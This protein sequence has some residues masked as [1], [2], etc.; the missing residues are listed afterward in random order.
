MVIS[1][2]VR[3]WELY[4]LRLL[5][6]GH[7]AIA[8]LCSLAGLTFV[9]EAIQL[10]E[11]RRFLERLLADEALP[12]LTEIPGHPREEYV[13][14]V[15]ERFAQGGV[16]DQLARLCIGGTA[17]FPVFLVPTVVD[18][19]AIGGPVERAA[20]A[21]AGWARYL[22]QVPVEEQASDAPRGRGAVVRTAGDGDPLRFLEL[23]EVFPPPVRDSDRFR[24]AFASAW[25]DIGDRGPLAAMSG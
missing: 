21:L 17:K 2:D 15:L 18:Q 8:Y 25:R 20:T 6:A 13:A 3:A 9:D 24:D 14:S 4:K 10:P 1:D 12:T 23:G 19:L 22:D 11:V 16:R 5:N 7:S